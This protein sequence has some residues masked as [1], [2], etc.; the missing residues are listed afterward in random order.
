MI[1]TELMQRVLEL[2]DEAIEELE[3]VIP[4]AGEYFDDKWGYTETLNRIKA[5]RAEFE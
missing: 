3:S 1:N 4:Y 2:L 5:E